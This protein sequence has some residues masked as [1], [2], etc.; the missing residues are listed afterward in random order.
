MLTQDSAK[1]DQLEQEKLI[2]TGSQAL[3]HTCRGLT[4][5]WLSEQD[6]GHHILQKVLGSD[7][8]PDTIPEPRPFLPSLVN[9]LEGFNFSP[10]DSLC[11]SH[12]VRTD[13]GF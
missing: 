8:S 13:D 4:P 3:S 9:S 5:L 10:C 6:E 2:Q 12:S 7:F 1:W 11:R